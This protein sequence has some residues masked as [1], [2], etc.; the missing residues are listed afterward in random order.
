MMKNAPFTG[1][2]LFPK[3]SGHQIG[4]K[5]M[6]QFLRTHAPGKA[7]QFAYVE[8]ET[9]LIPHLTIWENLQMVMGGQSWSEALAMMDPNSRT[10]ANLIQ[11]PF[12]PGHA[13]SNWE[14]FTLALIKGIQ[15]NSQH[16]LIDIS[17]DMHT[18]LNLTN[19][20]KVLVHIS[21]KQKVFLASAN[22]SFWLDISN[23]VVKKD[24]YKFLIEDHATSTNT[25][26]SA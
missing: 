17:E 22:S 19:L 15:I 5:E 13:A 6:L 12:T 11:D 21:E 23:G 14:R 25:R 10:L 9:A 3:I 20:K 8:C 24:G 26:R 18:P 4:L 1:L 2:Y 7:P 16:L